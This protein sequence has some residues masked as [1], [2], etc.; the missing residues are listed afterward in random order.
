MGHLIE[1]YY[2][3]IFISHLHNIT[4]NLTS[5]ANYINVTSISRGVEY[6]IT[7]YGRNL[8]CTSY[9]GEKAM[10]LMTLDGMNDCSIMITFII[11]TVPD[12]PSNLV[13]VSLQ[14][15]KILAIWQVVHSLN[16][17]IVVITLHLYFLTATSILFSST[18]HVLYSTTQCD[19]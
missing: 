11:I 15:E 10:L 1:V 7:V 3:Q 4:L 18:C 17:L 14:E 9:E 19:Y 13:A 16:V 12:Q 5:P 2:I 6:I 8:T